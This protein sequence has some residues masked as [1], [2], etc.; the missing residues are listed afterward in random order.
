MRRSIK[1]K[2]NAFERQRK[3]ANAIRDLIENERLRHARKIKSLSEQVAA[4]LGFQS[5]D[6]KSLAL[7]RLEGQRKDELAQHKDKRRALE[8]RLQ[9]ALR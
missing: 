5:D 6:W 7:V 2:K 3:K 8:Q 1:P 4:A 9:E